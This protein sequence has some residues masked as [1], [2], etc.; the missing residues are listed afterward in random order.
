M[1]RINGKQ[2]LEW[3]RLECMY[4]EVK[5]AVSNNKPQ[6]VHQKTQTKAQFIQDLTMVR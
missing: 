1:I 6:T 3:L 5:C 2:Q 4:T